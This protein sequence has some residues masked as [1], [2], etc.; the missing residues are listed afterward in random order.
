MN[1][2][3]SNSLTP[4]LYPSIIPTQSPTITYTNCSAGFSCSNDEINVNQGECTGYRSCNNMVY[5]QGGTP[6]CVGSHSCLDSIFTLEGIGS[7]V[8]DVFG[9]LSFTGAMLDSSTNIICCTKFRK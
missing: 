7:E 1:V 6:D 4:T 9:Y 2:M 8:I 5:K 3:G